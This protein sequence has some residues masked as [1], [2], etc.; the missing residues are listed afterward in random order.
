M[1]SA[2]VSATYIHA[3]LCIQRASRDIDVSLGLHILITSIEGDLARQDHPQRGCT[4]VPAGTLP[5][6]AGTHLC[7]MSGK[8]V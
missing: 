6:A 8:G 5:E 1:R 4:G 3:S 2:K 7:F